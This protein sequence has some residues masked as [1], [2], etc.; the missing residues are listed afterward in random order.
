[1]QETSYNKRDKQVM[2]FCL[3][4]F[5]L[6]LDIMYL[7]IIQKEYNRIDIL[8]LGYSK[9]AFS[10]DYDL[11]RIVMSYVGTIVFVGLIVCKII[12]QDRP[13]EILA[14]ALLCVSVMP[15]FTMFAYSEIHWNFFW[16][17][18]LFWGWMY[19]FIFTRNF[20]SDLPSEEAIDTSKTKLRRVAILIFWL[21]A[22][23]FIVGSVLFSYSYGEGFRFSFSFKNDVVYENRLAARGTIGL[24][25]NYFRNNAMFV[26]I[27]ILTISF[28]AKKRYIL[29]L[30]SII[31]LFL[32]FGVDS[33]KTVIFLAIVS[34]I[35]AFFLNKKINKTIIK[36]LLIV[37]L[38]VIVEYLLTGRIILVDYLVK[39]IYFLPAIIGKCFYEYVGSNGNQVFFSSLLQ[40]Y[41]II[42]NYAYSKVQL[43]FLIG[44]YYF[45]SINISANTGGFGGAY[46]YGNIALFV[47]PTIYAYLFK[48][49]DIVTN[50]IEEKYY[51]SFVILNTYVIT[52]SSL[53]SVLIVY[54][55]L[56]GL[57][58]LAIMNNTGVFKYDNLKLPKIKLKR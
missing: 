34:I 20:Q 23:A 31:V 49:L 53:P 12:K 46:A 29:F 16:L 18:C 25:T 11:L 44:R 51:I 8:L 54:G 22:I 45:G 4:L 57:V 42:S 36:G 39:R 50:N 40:K 48:I 10:F 7:Y 15:N 1:M 5:R 21:I 2:S 56:V 28:M 41:G 37:N 55:Y 35:A 27:P 38:F 13:H 6:T 58:L 47:I 33:Q 32:L 3:L 30:A 17:F 43:P 14:I 24:I 52:N 19:I 9:G 26:V